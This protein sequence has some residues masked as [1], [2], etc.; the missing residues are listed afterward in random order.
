MAEK[1]PELTLNRSHVGSK[2]SPELGALHANR[3]LYRVINDYTHIPEQREGGAKIFIRLRPLLDLYKDEGSPEFIR[4]DNTTIAVK[5]PKE[6]TASENIYRFNGIFPESIS[7]DTV[8]QS[9]IRPLVE[10][11]IDGYNSCVFAYGNNM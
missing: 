5:N 2:S 3:S 11:T 7:Q 10:R 6:M 9:A 8:F 4:A 1:L